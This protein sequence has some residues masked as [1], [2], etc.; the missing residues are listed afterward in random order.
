MACGCACLG[1]DGRGA[2]LS[3]AADPHHL[4][5]VAQEGTKW[6]RLIRDA[7]IKVD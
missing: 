6:S 2:D 4:V 7:D 3:V 5:V 1:A